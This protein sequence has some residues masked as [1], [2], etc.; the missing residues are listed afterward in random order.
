VA[1]FFK[2]I[3]NFCHNLQKLGFVFLTIINKNKKHFK[4]KLLPFLCNQ[5]ILYSQNAEVSKTSYPH[6]VCFIPVDRGYNIQSAATSRQ[7]T[8]NRFIFGQ[9][10]SSPW[11]D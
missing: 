9:I 6:L 4:G 8:G 3:L 1:F 10:V 2:I 7:K 11:L 5:N